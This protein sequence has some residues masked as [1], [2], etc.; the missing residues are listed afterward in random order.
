MYVNVTNKAFLEYN[1]RKIT[2]CEFPNYSLYKRKLIVV[3]HY[4][5]KPRFR[6]KGLI[7]KWEG[8][9][10]PFCPIFIGP[11]ILKLAKHVI[12]SMH[13]C[14]ANKLI[15]IVDVVITLVAI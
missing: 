15:L 5:F 14:C 6:F 12:M 2:L 3:R 9:K 8:V 7:T 13:V 11:L 1:L 4:V 10:H